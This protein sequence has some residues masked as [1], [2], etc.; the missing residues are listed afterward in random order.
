MISKKFT[1][2]SNE[3]EVNDLCVI[4]LRDED[5]KLYFFLTNQNDYISLMYNVESEENKQK[6]YSQFI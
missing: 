2:S 1:F 3:I 6:I 5:K 4:Y